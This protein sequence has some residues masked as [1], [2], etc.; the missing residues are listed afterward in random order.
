ML[1]F[2]HKKEYISGPAVDYI[3]RWILDIE[4]SSSAV[5]LMKI[6]EIDYCMKSIQVRIFYR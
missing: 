4:A 2:K 6:S 3:L 1:T 5:V